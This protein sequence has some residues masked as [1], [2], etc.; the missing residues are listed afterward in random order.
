MISKG[1]LFN[2]QNISSWLVKSQL[3]FLPFFFLKIV[4]S[5][6][7]WLLQNH[8]K[9]FQLS[10]DEFLHEMTE[11]NC[12]A[13]NWRYFGWKIENK[14]SKLLINYLLLFYFLFIL[15]QHRLQVFGPGHLELWDGSGILHQPHH[16]TLHTR[17]PT[18]CTFLLY[19][20][21]ESLVVVTVHSPSL[22]YSM[23]Q[24]DPLTETWDGIFKLE[25]MQ[26]SIYRK[27]FR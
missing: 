4:T 3:V 23:M 9:R 21:T 1:H 5:G 11:T 10:W 8:G 6:K 2:K 26:K 17:Q 7:I 25:P 13:H 15:C 18:I 14:C 22:S 16:P 20:L 19:L 24:G 12:W 27:R